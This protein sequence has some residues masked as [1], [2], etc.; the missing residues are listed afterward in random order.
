M[1][2]S[3]KNEILEWLVAHQKLSLFGYLGATREIIYCIRSIDAKA[4]LE[5]FKTIDEGGD[6]DHTET[7]ESEEG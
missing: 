4:F 1:T 3:E 7:A 5:R 6:Q 2:K